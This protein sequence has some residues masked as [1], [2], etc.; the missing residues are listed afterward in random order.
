MSGWTAATYLTAASVVIG[1]GSAI[2]SGQQQAAAAEAQAISEQNQAD[3]EADVARAHAEKIRKAG[4]AAKGEANVALAKSGVKLGE[5]TALEVQKEI[6]QNVE[7]DAF[8]ALLSGS[9]AKRAGEEEASML[10][11]SGDA[12]VTSSVLKAAGTVVAGGWKA[13]VKGQ[14]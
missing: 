7:Q 2:Y 3:A 4:R 6:T 12:A 13:S 11:A 8:A 14:K 5:G 10:R 9:R 1:A